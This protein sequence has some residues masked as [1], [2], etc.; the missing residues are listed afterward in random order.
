MTDSEIELL[1]RICGVRFVLAKRDTHNCER[2]VAPLKIRVETC[3][4]LCRCYYRLLPKERLVY[5]EHAALNRF[6]EQLN[7]KERLELQKTGIVPLID[8]LR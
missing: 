8:S 6:A 3:G 2:I 4:R 5:A 7:M 1:L